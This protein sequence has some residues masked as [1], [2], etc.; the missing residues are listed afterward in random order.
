VAARAD[1][2]VRGRIA[3]VTF[4]EFSASL[5]RERAPAELPPGLRA[6]WLDA[7]GDWSAAHG[8]A[9]DIE[10]GE[11]ARIHAYLHRKEG[12]VGNAHY[13]YRHAGRAP[14]TGSLEQEWTALVRGLLG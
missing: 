9:Q 11:G 13:W 12:D 8:V 3:A 7:K 1:R 4:E 14:V 10:T 6:L 5:A 2:C